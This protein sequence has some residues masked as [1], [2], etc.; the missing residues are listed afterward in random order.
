M[1]L[2]IA[3]SVNEPETKKNLS[4]IVEAIFTEYKCGDAVSADRNTALYVFNEITRQIGV[5]RFN[6]GAMKDVELM[7]MKHEA[8]FLVENF[9]ELKLAELTLLIKLFS[10][11]KLNAIYHGTFAPLYI[12]EVVN[13]YF[14]YSQQQQKIL[15]DKI[16][17][18]EIK[19]SANQNAE[20]MKYIIGEVYNQLKAGEGYVYMLNDV[21]G[22]FRRK[23]KIVLDDVSMAEAKKYA[24]KKIFELSKK[25]NKDKKEIKSIR[26]AIEPGYSSSSKSNFHLLFSN[27]FFVNRLYEK[28]KLSELLALVSEKDFEK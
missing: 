23:G 8:T 20:S 12:G 22:Y 11:G 24:D 3:Q 4:E 6:V 19:P 15:I 1:Y 13:A 18:A 28:N 25:E 27:E 10:T 26:A 21:F 16:P 7:Q 2:Q 17:P 9:P 14:S 5:W